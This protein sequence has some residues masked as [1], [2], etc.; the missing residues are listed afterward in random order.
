MEHPQTSDDGR[1][2]LEQYAANMRETI[3][4]SNTPMALVNINTCKEL[5]DDFSDVFDDIFKCVEN[6]SVL[7]ESSEPAMYRL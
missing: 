1:Y 6:T 7:R 5:Y 3:H 4:N 2:L